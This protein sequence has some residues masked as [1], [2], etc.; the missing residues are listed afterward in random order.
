MQSKPQTQEGG[1]GFWATPRGV[2]QP[3]KCHDDPRRAGSNGPV[4]KEKPT[5]SMGKS[6]KKCRRLDRRPR[7]P[8]SRKQFERSRRPRRPAQRC[9]ERGRQRQRQRKSTRQER[10]TGE[11]KSQRSQRDESTD[12]DIRCVDKGLRRLSESAH[13][14]SRKRCWNVR[15]SVV[16]QIRRRSNPQGSHFLRRPWLGFP[17]G[18]G[19]QTARKLRVKWR[20]CACVVPLGRLRWTRVPHN[21]VDMNPGYHRIDKR[22]IRPKL[23]TCLRIVCRCGANGEYPC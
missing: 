12:S 23:C 19:P 7:P 17:K 2:A 1:A 13:R 21:R 14:K 22:K 11:V 3:T 5:K 8:R 16:P 4:G 20:L 18:Q 9:H 6:T 15:S 10:G